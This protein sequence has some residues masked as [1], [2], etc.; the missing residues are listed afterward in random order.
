MAS[1][2]HGTFG[3]FNAGAASP[4]HI[5]G[6]EYYGIVIEGSL[7]NP[8]NGDGAPPVL[9]RGGFWRVP[10]DSVH[11]TACEAGEDCRFYFH[12]RAGFDFRLI[13]DG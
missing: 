10:A 8:F 1:G 11:V 5:H 9:G 2:E 6:A 13:C 12:S 7:T 3:I 4:T